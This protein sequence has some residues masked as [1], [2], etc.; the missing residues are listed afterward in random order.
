MVE[1]E[2][3]AKA[4]NVKGGQDSYSNAVTVTTLD[5]L[6]TNL[7]QNNRYIIIGSQFPNSV[8][9]SDVTLTHNSITVDARSAGKDITFKTTN[10]GGHFFL[11]GPGGTNIIFIGIKFQIDAHP[12]RQS[13]VKILE[14]QNSDFTTHIWFHRCT[15]T[16]DLVNPDYF[17]QVE[18]INLEIDSTASVTFSWCKFHQIYDM[19]SMRHDS[20]KDH[21]VTIHHSIFTN[22][23]RRQPASKGVNGRVHTYNV[24]RKD[25]AN[26]LLVAQTGGKLWDH[27]SAFDPPA[28]VNAE[29]PICE[30]DTNGVVKVNQAR[31]LDS[32]CP[33]ST[34]SLDSF[35]ICS[36]SPFSNLQNY[37]FAIQTVGNQACP[38]SCSKVSCT[39]RDDWVDKV[40]SFAGSETTVSECD[41]PGNFVLPQNFLEAVSIPKIKI[42]QK[43][44][45]PN[46]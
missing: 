27:Y 1:R 12:D 34:C 40:T 31:C 11:V 28:E 39:R 18:G 14:T 4:Y 5:D 6:L 44:L 46:S 29:N 25:W 33:F 32:S 2:G 24:V 20:L 26:S 3:F 22:C 8:V 17:P 43:S 13:E 42:P 30:A 23:H 10:N 7:N 21:F 36:V 19:I 15:F 37:K 35:N 9:I 38:S 41:V 45:N 16:N